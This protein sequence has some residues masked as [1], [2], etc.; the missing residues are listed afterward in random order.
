MKGCLSKQGE[1]YICRRGIL[2]LQRCRP[3]GDNKACSDDCPLFSEPRTSKSD[4]RTKLELCHWNRTIFFDEGGF[5][6]M[7]P[8]PK[9]PTEQELYEEVMS[10]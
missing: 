9:P 7:R 3:G 10:L 5:K 2:K 8:V 6:D 4:K 1:L